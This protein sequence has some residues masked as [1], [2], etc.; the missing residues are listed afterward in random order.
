VQQRAS[1]HEPDLLALIADGLTIGRFVLGVAL[2]PVLGSKRITLAA[3]ILGAAWLTDFFDGRAA[4][5][6]AGTTR[7]GPLDLWADTVVGAGAVLGFVASGWL[8]AVL[9]IGLVLAL[10]T[11]F[12]IA[13]NEA[14]S[15]I[16]QAAG[17]ALVLWHVWR[18]GYGL[19]LA[20]LLAI[21][22]VVAFVNRRVVWERSLPTF[23]G[24]VA[25][26]LRGG[27]STR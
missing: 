13:R 14:L 5:A 4:R 24:G 16:L 25:G 12:A 27:R 17:Y 26:L 21:I 7:F 10:V 2:V 3:S 15:M 18:D 9:G 1:R 19:A 11:W 8:P 23:F 20:W 22:A 6:S